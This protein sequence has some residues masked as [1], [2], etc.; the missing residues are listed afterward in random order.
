M[1]YMLLI[2][3][4]PE[5]RRARAVEESRDAYERMERF[6][7][8]LRARRILKASD[9][10]RPDSEAVR[11]EVRGGRRAVVDGPFAEC[12]EIIGGFFLLDCPTREEAIA[13]AQECPA[14]EWSTVEVREV[15]RCWED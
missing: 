15:G 2:V 7:N 12:K 11:V 4:R 8:D 3:E 14:A 6:S 13:I 1:P 9:A 10:L 5:N